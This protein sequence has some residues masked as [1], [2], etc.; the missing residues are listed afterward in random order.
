M[1]AEDPLPA[2]NGP[3]LYPI[4]S[5]MSSVH[6]DWT[7]SLK[8]NLQVSSLICRS[9]LKGLFLPGFPKKV[10]F[11]V[12]PMSAAYPAYPTLLHLVALIIFGEDQVKYETPHYSLFHQLFL[13]A[14]S[15]F[16]SWNI[17]LSPQPMKG[18]VTFLIISATKNT[19]SW[20]VDDRRVG[21]RVPV[22]SRI[23]SLPRRPDRLWGAPSLLSNGYCRV[24]RPGVKRPGHEADH[25]PP[26]TAE[27]KKMWLYT[28]TPPYFFL[29]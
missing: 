11:I 24:F 8:I 16:L 1:E 20:E 10:K 9:F 15:F 25:S 5:Y 4:L 17:L 27:V 18:D 14:I 21:V 3:P 28:S 2:H 26:T 13:S 6:F 19:R 7:Y 29:A 22:G 23:F 12:S